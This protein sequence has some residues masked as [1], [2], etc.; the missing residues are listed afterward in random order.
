MGL[1][2]TVAAGFADEPTREAKETGADGV[3]VV[4]VG[5]E[6]EAGTEVGAGACAAGEGVETGATVAE[7]EAEAEAGAG[8]VVAACDF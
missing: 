6:V 1:V 7:A 5:A 8:A 2:L 3:E 4:A